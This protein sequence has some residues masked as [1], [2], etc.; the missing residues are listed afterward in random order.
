M[1][2]Q[3]KMSSGITFYIFAF[4]IVILALCTI[5][6]PKISWSIFCCF[7]FFLFI[8]GLYFSMNSM[9]LGIFQFIIFGIFI[10]AL[11]FIGARQNK[12][13]SFAFPFVKKPRLFLSILFGFLILVLIG[14]LINYFLKTNTVEEIIP[15]NGEFISSKLLSVYLIVKTI[16]SN[17]FWAYMLVFLT[18]FAGLTDVGILIPKKKA[19]D[20]NEQ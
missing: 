6:L 19:E 7:L 8:S 14:M 15:A 4:S 16:F 9:F 5:I 2:E 13:K 20:N 1:E 12:E 18:L 3:T 17:Y 10:G 11:L